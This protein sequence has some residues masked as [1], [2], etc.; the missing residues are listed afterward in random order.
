MLAAS[1]VEQGSVRSVKVRVWCFMCIDRWFDMYTRTQGR[2]TAEASTAVLL[3]SLA[4]RL[5]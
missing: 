1:V 5:I 3:F 2:S 4:P